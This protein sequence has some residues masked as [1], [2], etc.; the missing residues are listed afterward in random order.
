MDINLEA[1]VQMCGGLT[2]P[3][4]PDETSIALANKHRVD[5]ETKLGRKFSQWVVVKSSTQV[6]AGTNH[7]VKVDVGEGEFIHLKIYEKLPC[8]GGDSELSDTKAGLTLQSA[9]N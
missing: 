6:V 7:F 9:F 4:A 3:G 5:A 8:Y 2:A 1:N